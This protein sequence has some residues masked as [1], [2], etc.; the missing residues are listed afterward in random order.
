LC[1]IT[2]DPALCPPPPVER[3]RPT[4]WGPMNRGPS[5]TTQGRS[6]RRQTY[7]RTV[8]SFL[9]RRTAEVDGLHGTWGSPPSRTDIDQT[10][11]PRT[12]KIGSGNPRPL[13]ASG[14]QKR[15]TPTE[16]ARPDEKPP[17]APKLSRMD[18]ILNMIEE[19]AN[20]Q[21]ELLRMLRKRFFH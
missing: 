15:K 20:T 2:F 17:P 10:A 19:Y 7:A 18:E 16:T 12:E 5:E 1:S 14:P 6:R 3:P 21:R 4:S 9:R 8:G 13:C 11:L